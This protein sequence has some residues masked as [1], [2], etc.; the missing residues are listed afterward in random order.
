MN[1]DVVLQDALSSP[2]FDILTIEL[3]DALDGDQQGVA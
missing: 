1:E 3:L 2:Q